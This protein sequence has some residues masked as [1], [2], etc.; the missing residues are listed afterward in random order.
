MLD[1]LTITT[2]VS[3]LHIAEFG[4]GHLL[5]KLCYMQVIL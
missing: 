5:I 3:D 2:P 4:L 1:L